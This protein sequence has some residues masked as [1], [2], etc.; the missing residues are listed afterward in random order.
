MPKVCSVPLQSPA[1]HWGSPHVMLQPREDLSF[2]NDF[3]PALM[4][5]S[6]FS[7]SSSK[8]ALLVSWRLD[9]TI[10]GWCCYIQFPFLSCSGLWPGTE[11]SLCEMLY[12]PESVSVTIPKLTCSGPSFDSWSCCGAADGGTALEV[13]TGLSHLFSLFLESWCRSLLRWGG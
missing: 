3:W 12:E 10:P 1:E 9:G 4:P 7:Y 2:R 8:W 11:N 13:H 6:H 5:S